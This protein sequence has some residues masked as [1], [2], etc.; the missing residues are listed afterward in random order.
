MY[1]TLR[2]WWVNAATGPTLLVCIRMVTTV[3]ALTCA[4]AWWKLLHTP[5]LEAT[6]EH[7]DVRMFR[8]VARVLVC[9]ALLVACYTFSAGVFEI[10][11]TS[12]PNRLLIANSVQAVLLVPLTF[13]GIFLQ[14]VYTRKVATKVKQARTEAA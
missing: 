13:M 5:I 1:E 14:F 12:S 7:R 4:A 2:D 9:G 6:W 11:R 8:I 10:E 3:L